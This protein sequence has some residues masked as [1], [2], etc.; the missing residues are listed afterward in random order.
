MVH[1]FADRNVFPRSSTFRKVNVPMTNPLIQ[2]WHRVVS[3][4]IW[5]NEKIIFYPKLR[6]FYAKRIPESPL[7]FDVG[8]NRGQTIKFF[9]SIF[10]KPIIHAFEPSSVVLD[11]LRKFESDSVFLHLFALGAKSEMKTFYECVFD[12]VSSLQKPDINSAYFKFKSKVLLTKPED[13]LQEKVV[14]VRTID[15]IVSENHIECINVLKIDVEGHELEVL[16]G[17]TKSLGKGIIKYL[18][19][20]AHVDGQYSV[21]PNEIEAFLKT[22]NYKKSAEIKHGFGNFYDMIFQPLSQAGVASV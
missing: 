6:S 5:T 15:E 9:Q 2:L 4:G 10:K 13:M 8:A 19:L 3:G 7:I 14:S 16:R 18:Q 17:A 12:E 20:E 21:G 11:E 1:F 22:Y